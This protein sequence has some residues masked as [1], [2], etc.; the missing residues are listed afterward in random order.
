[1]TA[2]AGLFEQDTDATVHIRIR[3]TL[4]VVEIVVSFL[5]EI[6]RSDFVEMFGMIGGDLS[7]Q[8]LVA[9]GCVTIHACRLPGLEEESCIR[10]HLMM[11]GQDVRFPV[12]EDVEPVP[13]FVMLSRQP[14]AVQVEP[15]MVETPAGPCLAEFAVV[16]VAYA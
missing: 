12:V 7:G 13:T 14:V 15:V 11:V 4:S 9:F 1:M 8:L 6:K 16:R 3:G 5:G 2:G 10:T